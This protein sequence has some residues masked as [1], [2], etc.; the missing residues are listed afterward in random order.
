MSDYSALRVSLHYRGKKQQGMNV[1][2]IIE[3]VCK[4]S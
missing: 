4:E 1:L 2:S 3:L